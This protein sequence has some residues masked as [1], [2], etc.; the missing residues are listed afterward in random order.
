M[1][2]SAPR[3]SANGYARPE[4]RPASGSATALSAAP[5]ARPP[6]PGA[7]RRT[8]ARRPPAHRRTE[9]KPVH[10]H[11]RDAAAGEPEHEQPPLRGERPQ[12]VRRP[13]APDRVEHDVDRPLA[14]NLADRGQ[15]S[16]TQHR[17]VRAAPQRELPLRLIPGD[18]DRPQPQRLPQ[19]DGRGPDASRRAVH[20][21]RLARQSPCPPDQREQ[22]GQVVEGAA[23]PASKLIPSGS[24]RTRSGGTLM[25]SCQQPCGTSTATR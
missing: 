12:A 18:R 9:Q 21:Q 2:R 10:L 13:V 24:G 6:A 16:V 1:A 11:H 15:P 3:A 14:Q 4:D 23:A 22:A 19:L 17:V 25:T 7:A 20:K 8:R 5:T